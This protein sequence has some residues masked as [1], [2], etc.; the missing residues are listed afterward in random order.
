MSSRNLV[1]ATVGLV[2]LGAIAYFAT[3]GYP[4]VDEGTQATVGTAQRYQKP[5]IKEGDVRVT[6]SEV[7]SFMQSDVFDKLMKDKAAVAALSSR[8]CRP[9]SRG[10]L[11][12]ALA[13]P[14]VA[15]AL[16]KADSPRP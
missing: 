1:L 11:A 13:R 2:A 10:G 6:E 8:R 16:S 3:K 9:H 7:Q 5:Q 15:A 14:E 4:P 12:A